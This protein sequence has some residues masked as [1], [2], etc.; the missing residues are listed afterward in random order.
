MFEKLSDVGC[1][2]H[3][4]RSSGYI[5]SW[6]EEKCHEE[7]KKAHSLVQLI[8]MIVIYF[9]NYYL[10]LLLKV[11]FL[12]FFDLFFDVV[13]IL[14]SYVCLLAFFFAQKTY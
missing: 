9:F 8:V 10:I 7:C 11:L 14:Y 13:I 3:D 4:R 6:N 1:D 12:G 2:L 5:A